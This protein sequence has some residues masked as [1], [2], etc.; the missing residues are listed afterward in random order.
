M[1]LIDAGPLVAIANPADHQH[2]IVL[3]V[4][5]QNREQ[6][7]TTWPVLAEAAWLLRK[8]QSSIPEMFRGFISGIFELRQLERDSLIW[9]SR[10]L[11]KYADIGAQ[12]A[13]ASL[14]YVA[15][16]DDIDTVFTLDRRDFTVY[17]TTKNRALKIVP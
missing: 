12:I 14:M 8:R 2:A 6:L 1:I 15:E 10:F 7:V 9:I 5:R 3:E 11:Q 17:R 4:L 13:D 16:F